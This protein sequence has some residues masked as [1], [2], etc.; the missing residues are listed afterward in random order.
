MKV[1]SLFSGA[2]CGDLGLEWAGFEHAWFC[3]TD[4]YARQILAMRWPGKTIYGD[5][6][7]IDFTSVPS[8]DVLAGG[9]PC[10]DIS[11][12]GPGKGIQGERS[13]LWSEYAR[14]IAEIRPRYALIE[15]SAAL[16]VRGLDS[17]LS[18]LAALGYDAEWH[19]IPAASFGAPHKRDRIWIVAY[20]NSSRLKEYSRAEPIHQEHPAVEC[21]SGETPISNTKGDRRSV[22]RVGAFSTNGIFKASRCAD[23]SGTRFDGSGQWWEAEPG[24]DRVVDG[25]SNRVDRLRCIGNGQVPHCTYFIGRLIQEHSRQTFSKA[26]GMK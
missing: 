12:A 19:C 6:K 23:G 16:V 13:G 14:A 18:D 8:V 4:E 10:Q 2:G 7:E 9:F 20:P 26:V 21:G 25:T 3:E 5:I 11:T 22:R 17:V 1:G 24:L 15:N